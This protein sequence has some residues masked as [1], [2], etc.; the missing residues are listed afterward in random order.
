LPL[1]MV[2]FVLVEAA[3]ELVP[4]EL[5]RSR[6]VVSSARRRGVDP[7]GM[8][9][10]ISYHYRSMRKHLRDWFKR[11][12]PDIIHTTLLTLGSSILWRRGM[13]RA[14]IETRHG[15]VF[16]REG[17]RIVRNYNRFVGLMEQVLTK[18]SAPP[19]SDKPLIYL[20]ERDLIEYI[21]SESPDLVILLDEKGR[22][23]DPWILGSRVAGSLK[24]YILIGGFQKGEFS[25]R[26]LSAGFERISI[27]DES[28]DAWEV[29]CKITT[30]IERALGLDI[31]GSA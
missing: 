10:D 11:G 2:T 9:L 28:L 13:A 21:R 14:V 18:G 25:E 16:V 26:I 17:V 1:S 7:R 15:L 20:V 3:L 12:R 22:R 30:S 8:L 6:D 24:P 23:E 29:V 4:P 5:V 27:Y 31:L 19:G